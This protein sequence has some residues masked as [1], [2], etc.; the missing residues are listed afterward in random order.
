MKLNGVNGYTYS[1]IEIVSTLIVN[2]TFFLAKCVIFCWVFNK[3]FQGY[4]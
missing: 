2:G 1:P 3:L 4:N